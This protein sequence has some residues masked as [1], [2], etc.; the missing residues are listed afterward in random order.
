M[1][2]SFWK[3]HQ[4]KW[5]RQKSLHFLSKHSLLASSIPTT[6][7]SN[8]FMYVFLYSILSSYNWPSCSPWIL[9]FTLFTNSSLLFL[10]I[11]Q[12]TSIYFF[13]PIPLHHISLNL[14]K[15]PSHTLHCSHLPILSRHM[16][17]SDNLFPQHTLLTDVSYSM[18][19]FLIHLLNVGRIL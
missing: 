16:I 6:S 12:I 4:R 14:H 18:S 2:H 15:V 17:L 3:C 5:P 11:C 7:I 19:K 8:S 10:F 1:P 13:S 9:S